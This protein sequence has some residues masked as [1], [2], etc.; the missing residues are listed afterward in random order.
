MKDVTVTVCHS[1]LSSCVVVVKSVV[2]VMCE[3]F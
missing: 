2:V 1:K 3:G